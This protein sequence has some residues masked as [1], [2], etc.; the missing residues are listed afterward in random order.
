[1]FTGLDNFNIY[2]S[3]VSKTSWAASKV[4]DNISYSVTWIYGP[5]L[6]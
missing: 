6:L 2:V 4:A 5:Y 3:Y 1:M